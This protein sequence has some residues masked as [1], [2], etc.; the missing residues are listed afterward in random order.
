[1][2]TQ[3]KLEIGLWKDTL[4]AR[5]VAIM[6]PHFKVVSSSPDWDGLC[7]D[8]AEAMLGWVGNSQTQIRVRAYD[9]EGTPP[10]RPL[11]EAYRSKGAAGISS[12]NRDV[13]L[14]LS[15]HGG[16]GRPSE[17]GRLYVP[18]Y[19]AGLAPSGATANTTS[20]NKAAA[21][22][23]ILTGLGGVNVDW[24][25]W[26]PKLRSSK[27]VTDWHVDN[28]W[29]TQRRRGMG[30]TSRLSGTT[31]EDSVPNL[32]SLVSI[33]DLSQPSEAS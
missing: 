1:V 32:V 20:L 31:T 4:E 13:A 19:A 14:C 24:V 30:A 29:D 25:V 18:L 5:D 15:F 2:A 7:S 21:L 23:P 28:A 8:L 17:R 9:D 16:S 3:A 33:P 26:S 22:V 11:G 10:R 6:T 12:S 27:P